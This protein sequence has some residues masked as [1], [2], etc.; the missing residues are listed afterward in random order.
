MVFHL[1][2][3][4][5]VL[6]AKILIV[7]SLQEREIFFHRL[8]LFGEWSDRL[9]NSRQFCALSTF[10]VIRSLRAASF[11]DPVE[12]IIPHGTAVRDLTILVARLTEVL[13]VKSKIFSSSSCVFRERP[14]MQ[15]TARIHFQ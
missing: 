2:T 13:G 5:L 11:M 6:W 4:E 7:I 3:I 9:R 15:E 8:I 14:M 1:A 12:C 10:M